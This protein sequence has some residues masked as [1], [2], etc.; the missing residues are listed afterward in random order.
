MVINEQ[1]LSSATTHIIT[2]LNIEA[3]WKSVKTSKDT[4][5]QLRFGFIETLH[6][7]KKDIVKTIT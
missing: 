1:P 6:Q 4:F 2:K 5:G 7:A 3:Q